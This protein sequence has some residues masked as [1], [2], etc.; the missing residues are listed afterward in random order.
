MKLFLAEQ[1]FPM[2]AT[3]KTFT[4]GNSDGHPE[5]NP[6]LLIK[7]STRRKRV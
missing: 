3:Y 5:G 4:P 6:L 2:Q 7:S 1:K